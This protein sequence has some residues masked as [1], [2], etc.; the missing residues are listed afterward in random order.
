MFQAK[1]SQESVIP[2]ICLVPR[3]GLT[4]EP[5]GFRQEL[6][7]YGLFSTILEAMK[8]YV[9]AST[10]SLRLSPTVL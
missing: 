10:V 2:R 4:E 7:N 9:A 8:C 6:G 5:S 3:A 1:S